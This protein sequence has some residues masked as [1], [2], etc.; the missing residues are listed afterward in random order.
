MRKYETVA[1]LLK[2]P[3]RWTKRVMARTAFGR[4]CPVTSPSAASFC[5]IGAC[6]RVYNPVARERVFK[7]LN[8]EL[9]RIGSFSPAFFNDTHTHK[10]V[11][12]LLQKAN[13]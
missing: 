6:L 8:A 2:N 13:V 11:L 5:L 7:K 4:S 1:A 10:E 12:A 9:D 3:K